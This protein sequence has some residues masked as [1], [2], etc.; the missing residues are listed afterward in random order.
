MGKPRPATPEEIELIKAEAKKQNVNLNEKCAFRMSGS[1]NLIVSLNGLDV[2]V[3]NP[4]NKKVL[5]IKTSKNEL[6]RQKNELETLLTADAGIV[7]TE[8][9]QILPQYVKLSTNIE[10]YSTNI[11]SMVDIKVTREICI[12]KNISIKT[13]KIFTYTY[14]QKWTKES[15]KKDIGDF[16]QVSKKQKKM[17]SVTLNKKAIE[18]F[19]ALVKEY[20]DAQ[21]EL[22]IE[23]ALADLLDKNDIL[24]KSFEFKAIETA[25]TDCEIVQFKLCGEIFVYDL[26]TKK[27]DIKNLDNLKQRVK[28]IN[29]NKNKLHTCVKLSEKLHLSMTLQKS[30]NLQ[31]SAAFADGSMH[32]KNFDTILAADIQKWYDN[33]ASEINEQMKEKQEGFIQQYSQNTFY[34]NILADAIMEFIEKNEKYITEAAMIKNFRGLKNTFNGEIHDTKASGKLEYVSEE[35]ISNMLIS[36][37]NANIIRKEMYKGTYGTFYTLKKGV[38]FYIYKSIQYK[39]EPKS[40]DKFNDYDWIAYMEKVKKKGHEKKLTGAELMQQISLLDH[41]ALICLYPE[42]VSDFLQHKPESW[43]DYTEMMRDMETGKEKKFWKYVL[44]LKNPA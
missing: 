44:Q 27:L 9:L 25:K 5:N 41:K 10:S 7:M 6:K 40:F 15:L 39:S 34:C 28:Y 20:L 19:K 37:V 31:V 38:N 23:S 42:L 13:S 3:L 26:E 8:L 35:T 1:K 43:T 12:C 21:K 16:L 17:T 33:V 36:L 18:Y 4:K 29:K 22:Q 32:D 24:K 14:E 30:M 11:K 2:F